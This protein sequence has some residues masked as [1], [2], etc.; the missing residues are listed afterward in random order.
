[1]DLD[2]DLDLEMVTIASHD[3]DALLDDFHSGI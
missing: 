2:L 1:V 3:D